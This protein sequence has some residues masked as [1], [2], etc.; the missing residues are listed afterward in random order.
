MI[1]ANIKRSLDCLLANALR[2]RA[3]SLFLR[4]IIASSSR[5]ASE[6]NSKLH[7]ATLALD[8]L[9]IFNY[10][11]RYYSNRGNAHAPYKLYSL[12]YIP[13]IALETSFLVCSSVLGHRA[14]LLS[15]LLAC[16]S[17]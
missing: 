13:V 1:N 7:T 9:S 15:Q 11:R 6:T 3:W 12:V 4:S 8:L 5:F 14:R 16:D 10:L 17:N 2:L